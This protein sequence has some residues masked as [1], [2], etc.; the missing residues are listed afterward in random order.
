MLAI[1]KVN[2]FK[3]VNFELFNLNKISPKTLKL[4]EKIHNNQKIIYL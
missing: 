3:N 4:F 2:N 1:K